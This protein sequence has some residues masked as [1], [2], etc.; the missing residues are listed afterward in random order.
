MRKKLL[1][2]KIK[3]SIRLIICL[4]FGLL[5][6]T[7]MSAADT[8]TAD[9]KTVDPIGDKDHFSAVIY[10][11]SNGL[12]ASVANDI[13]QTK[14]GFIWIASYAGLIRYDG[15]R[16]ERIDT[17]GC[18]T[19]A[20]CLL[21]DSQDR[22]WIG[23]NESGIALMEKDG[24]RWW[25]E[26]NGLVSSKVRDIVEGQDGTIYVGTISGITIISP[27]QKLKTLN[28]PK[29]ANLYTERLEVGKDGIVYGISSQG[30]YFAIRKDKLI[31]YI[32][33][34]QSNIK[35]ITAIFPDPQDENMIYLGTEE[36]TIYHCKA[37]GNP[38]KI[39]S[40]DVSP[41]TGIG[42]MN[43]IDGKIWICARNGIGVLDKKGFHHLENLP[44]RYSVTS[45]IPD[46]QGNLWFSSSRQGAMK[47]TTNRFTDFFARYGIQEQVVN[48]TCMF[49]KKLF[50]GTETGLLVFDKNKSVSS[51]PLTEAKYASG[52]NYPASDL[53]TLLND[54]RIR[55]IIKDSKDRLWFSTW[56]SIGL[57]CYDHGKLTVFTENEGLPSDRVRAIHETPD[58][59]ILAASTGGLVVIKN[60]RITKCYDEDDGVNS[61]EILSVTT[62]PNGDII[63]GSNGGGIYI[64]NKK[65]TRCISQKDGLTSGVIMRIKY[66]AKRDVFWLVTGNSI[67]YMTPDY[68]ITTIDNFPYPDN[69]DL[70]E[71]SRGEM[72]VLSSDGIYVVSADELL[73][74][75]EISYAHYGIPNG[76]PG[77]VV[78]NSYNELT[79]NGDLYISG[80]TGVMKVNI[81]TPVNDNSELKQAVP[82]IDVDNVRYYPDIHGE[83]R[84]PSSAKKISIYGFL[85]NYSLIDP[86]VTFQLEGFDRYPASYRQSEIHPMSYTNLSGGTYRFVMK[87]KDELGN[88]S[89]M[90]S[91]TI[92]KE[93][94]IYESVLFYIFSG[95]ILM[96]IMYL[97]ARWYVTRNLRKMEKRH[98]DEAE[99]ERV[100]TELA[101]A[102]RI[103]MSVLPHEFPPFPNRHEFDVYASM[104][105]AREVGGDFYDYFLI[106][107]DHLGLVIADVSG[108]GIP[109]SLYMMNAK[110]IV[111]SIAKNGASPKEIL[112]R[113]NELICSNNPMEMFVTIWVGIVEISTGKVVA[114]NAGHEYPIIK[115]ADDKF[116]LFKDKHCFIIGGMEDIEYKE[117]EMQIQPGDKIFVYTDGLTE[118]TNSEKAMFGVDRIL[119]ALNED[120][121]ASPEQLLKNVRKAVDAFVQDAEQFDD[122]TMLCMEYRGPQ[123]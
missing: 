40:I 42:A 52:G 77:T 58:G 14:E 12:P 118:A 97:L 33:H 6:M 94:A 41:L 36:S 8:K 81:D 69:L 109:A 67:G 34:T 9:K 122:L 5:L 103:Q 7:Q 78:S 22:L 45:V 60:G 115:G 100:N 30:D 11:N 123:S 83:F 24:Y 2:K 27:K 26:D 112:K 51:I 82:F 110:I 64:I 53:W 62:A 56:Q 47:L 74:N 108:K 65:G 76:L 46:Y 107:D 16:F 43:Q 3:R 49:E 80:N 54:V 39:E 73:A 4:L 10:D 31:D 23:T 93:K 21:A 71:N 17:E 29:I 90:T 68:E 13:V 38:S 32:D 19:S 75:K 116:E 101:M 15:V 63:V 48:S 28:H 50:V 102:N 84:I 96:L 61:K 57:L 95:V 25:N 88:D 105:P 44:F 119:K 117:Y 66:D 91:V 20:G 59:T 120:V 35:K 37:K 1:S 18:P 114:A 106:D 72:W 87:L 85:F 104:D 89:K 113:V 70:F 111:Q 92:Y 98:R 86:E 79:E 121:N 99:R 55:S